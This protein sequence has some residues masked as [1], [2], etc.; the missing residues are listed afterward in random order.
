MTTI[1]SLNN[2]NLLAALQPIATTKATAVTNVN[3][4]QAATQPTD[5]VTLDLAAAA[6][7]PVYSTYQA[8]QPV[9]ESSGDNLV[10]LTMAGNMAAY[11]GAQQFNGLGSALL[12]QVASTGGDYSQSVLL[13]DGSESASEIATSQALLHTSATNQITLDVTTK[14]GVKVE[15]SLDSDTN[16]LG[17]HINVTNG[18]LSAADRNALKGLEKSFQSAID[19]LTSEPPALN[20]S[21]LMQYDS[22]VLSSVDFH[23]TV[24]GSSGAE[25][26]DFTANSQQRTL[27]AALPDGTIK[28]NVDMS[29][30][31]TIGGSAQQQAAATKSYLQQFDN[32]QQRGNGNQAL[33]SMFDAAFSAMNSNYVA[34][35]SGNSTPARLL[36]GA[37]R[38]LLSGLADFSASITQKTEHPNPLRYNEVD[39]FSY[40]VSQSTS[41]KS[42]DLLSASVK[43][44]QSSNL[45]ASF[46][47][48]VPET[49]VMLMGNNS[50]LQTYD[51]VQ[52]N[53][54][55][56]NE[57]DIAYD[58]GKLVDAALKQ[59]ANQSTHT[60]EYVTGELMKDT[61]TPT[62]K[63]WSKSYL[64]LLD[65]TDFGNRAHP[66]GG[67]QT[68]TS[69]S[70]YSVLQA[71][72]LQLVRGG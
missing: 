67:S 48:A 22:S 26:V 64:Q 34:Q 31:A 57:A 12:K 23:A 38:S 32:A 44:K 37:D 25:T 9:W 69:V 36:T 58:E 46:H 65:D 13:T 19:G 6:G 3:S 72:P 35:P 51:Y 33:V 56:S 62:S 45:Q 47:K 11:S 43:Q 29:S 28:L 18:T 70:Q 39:A 55:A 52:I 17:V 59:S 54:S 63:S 7:S 53:D 1:S 8:Y 61:T 20:L 4:S 40:Q 30:L 50:K 41:I 14:S 66:E 49:G 42:S 16:G 71:D 68:L 27:N 5:I 24:Q 60:I 15:I 10:S 21:G 2:A